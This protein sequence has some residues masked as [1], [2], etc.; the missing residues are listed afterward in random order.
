M[1]HNKRKTYPGRNIVKGIEIALI[2]AIALF[3]L[4]ALDE[5][6]SPRNDVP[7]QRVTVTEYRY[8]A[9]SVT[10]PQEVVPAEAYDAYDYFLM[11]LDNQNAQNYWDAI[12]DYTR[13]IELDPTLT[14]SWLNRGVAYEQLGR[15]CPARKD[16]WEWM[17]RNSTE[18]IGATVVP[19]EAQTLTMAEGRM[20]IIPFTATQGQLLSV[21]AESVLAGVVDPLILVLNADDMPVA[22]SDDV[23]YS[24]GDLISMNSRINDYVVPTTGTYALVV[25]HAGGGAV[26]DLTVNMLLSNPSLPNR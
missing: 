13:A 1:Y 12:E 6:F 22:A 23:L 25:S 20:Y 7:S 18:I 26:G 16:F 3:G 5:A 11:G 8:T 9:P 21:E 4:A 2:I 14:A 17:S 15:P 10:V 24:D 19:G